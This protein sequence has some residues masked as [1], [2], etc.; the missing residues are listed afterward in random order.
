MRTVLHVLVRAVVVGVSSW[1]SGWLVATLSGGT[2][3]NIGAGLISFAVTM[4]L[5]FAWAAMDARRR[6]L[7]PVLFVWLPVA[8]LVGLA[9]P[10]EIAL[11]DGGFDWDVIASDL[12][13]V[14]PFTAALVAVPAILGAVVGAANRG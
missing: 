12:A 7:T 6:G 5:S 2:D 3:A 1:L 11:G 4:V 9:T 10:F 13:M 8:V 14:S